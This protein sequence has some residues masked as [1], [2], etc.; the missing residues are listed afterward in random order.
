MEFSDKTIVVTGAS[1]GLGE[2]FA[3]TLAADGARVVL[4]ARRRSKLDGIANEIIAAGG[5]A[6]VGGDG[7]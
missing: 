2:H 7:T 5:K 6:P 1:S 4:T 3:R